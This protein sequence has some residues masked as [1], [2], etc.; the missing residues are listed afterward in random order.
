[1]SN[2]LTLLRRSAET[3]ITVEVRIAC[4][5]YLC[6]ERIA[7]GSIT[8]LNTATM[9]PS[10]AAA[11]ETI[12]RAYAPQIRQKAQ[13]QD[14]WT[15]AHEK[16]YIVETKAPIKL[17]PFQYWLL[18]YALDPDMPFIHGGTIVYS[19]I[20]KSGKTAIAALVARWIAE[21]W[22]GVNEIDCVAND[23]EQA[24]G[25]A[26][27]ALLQSITLDPAYNGKN[28]S[29]G[30]KII[31][32]GAEFLDNH[33][34]V[35]ALS[36]DYKGAAG[37]NPTATFWTELWAYSTEASRRLWEELTPPPTRTS[38]FRYVETYAGFTDE[39][40][41]LIDLYKLGM[42]GR[43]LTHDDIDWPFP[44]QPPVWVNERAHVFLYWDT[45]TE[46]NNNA[47]RRMPWQT[48]EYYAAQAATLRPNAF[49]RLHRN[50]WTGSTSAFI[51]IEWWN[52]CRGVVPPLADNGGNIDSVALVLAV[53]AS[54][55]NDCSAV[56]AVRRDPKDD[57][58]C[59]LQFYEAW[60]PTQGSPMDYSVIDASI[61]HTA[62][63]YNIV[64]C[65][66]DQ[67]QLHKL[68]TDLR[69]DGIVWCRVF[70][71]GA[72]REVADKMLY[73]MIRDRRITHNAGPDFDEHVM[74]AAAKE[75]TNEKMR[76]VKKGNSQHVDLLV[77]L[78]MAVFECMRLML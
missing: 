49:D 7:H 71:Q 64:E 25:R 63:R 27:E 45:A 43:Q 44:D 48:D 32:R 41:L 15:F 57:T 21:T 68:M 58:R 73:D 38:G 37:S 17:E 66:Y 33:S 14:L 39:S 51:P 16:F 9:S 29:V 54:I 19:T 78:S 67:F 11:I 10:K 62:A 55:T 53:D 76:I 36:S 52:A 70:S 24:R 1:M 35:N 4:L 60:Y 18:N 69:N 56:V 6:T 31:E 72:N 59:M 74:A 20:K 12:A 22:A 26:Y 8:V 3:C 50:L 5:G 2:S 47:A 65:A 13:S 23:R 42:E 61:R 40:D 28:T 46:A 77:A 75:T 30:W 34:K